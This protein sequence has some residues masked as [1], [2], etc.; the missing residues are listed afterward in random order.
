[1]KTKKC[2]NG[3]LIRILNSIKLCLQMRVNTADEEKNKNIKEQRW[4]YVPGWDGIGTG[5]LMA[6]KDIDDR[7][8]ELKRK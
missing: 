3:E 1:M 8:R 5:L 6:I 7:I 2:N 4:S